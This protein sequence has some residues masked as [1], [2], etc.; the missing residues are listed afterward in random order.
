MYSERDPQ[1]TFKKKSLP[2]KISLPVVSS[3]CTLEFWSQ[4]LWCRWLRTALGMDIFTE[5]ISQGGQEMRDI[6]TGSIYS[7][8]IHVH[9]Q[10]SMV[11]CFL[12]NCV[13]RIPCVVAE[14]KGN[15]PMSAAV[16]SLS[17]PGD[18]AGLKIAIICELATRILTVYIVYF[19]CHRCVPGRSEK[20]AWEDNRNAIH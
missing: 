15:T 1:T 20:G 14:I 16:Q 17:V 4:P 11:S 18:V 7:I 12:S 6:A 2:T 19:A 5:D 13:I 9:C 8:K 10:C 3:P